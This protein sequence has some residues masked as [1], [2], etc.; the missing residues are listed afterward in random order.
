MLLVR[1]IVSI[2]VSASLF[3]D[4]IDVVIIVAVIKDVVNYTILFAAV[5]IL[6]SVSLVPKAI[7]LEEK[8]RS[9]F[10][11]K[12]LNSVFKWIFITLYL[13]LIYVYE[14]TYN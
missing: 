8:S 6:H 5:R 10:L 14:P 1:P 13:V 2:S 4:P 11:K 9:S 3:L 12:N 7:S